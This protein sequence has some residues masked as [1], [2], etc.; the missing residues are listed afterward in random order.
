MPTSSFPH[1]ETGRGQ[2]TR[3]I[4][5][6]SVLT[7]RGDGKHSTLGDLR[8]VVVLCGRGATRWCRVVDVFQCGSI[9]EEVV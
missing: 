4:R 8:D 3:M 9:Q 1:T 5:D 6:H 2:E 7:E